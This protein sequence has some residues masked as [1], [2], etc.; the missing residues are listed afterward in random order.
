M[1]RENRELQTITSKDVGTITMVSKLKCP[2]DGCD[3]EYTLYDAKNPR[4]YKNKKIGKPSRLPNTWTEDEVMAHKIG[5]VE[6]PKARRIIGKFMTLSQK[7][8]K[9]VSDF[10]ND[11]K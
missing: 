7:D 5:H 6:S 9:E 10:I 2:I 3:A 1:R 11:L 8:K 4:L